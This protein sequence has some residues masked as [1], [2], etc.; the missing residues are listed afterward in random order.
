MCSHSPLL[1]TVS[2][3][4][5]SDNALCGVTTDWM[6]R[7]EGTYNA[8]GNKAIADAVRVA[9]SLTRLDVSLNMLNIGGEG[10]KLLRDAL[11]E[12]QGFELRRERNEDDDDDSDDE[13]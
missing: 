1:C 12:R 11:N 13:Y 4:N 9:G 2:Q 10:V 8:E 7:P 3:L 5:L 6:E